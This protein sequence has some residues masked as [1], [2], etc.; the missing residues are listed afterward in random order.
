MRSLL[1][2]LG[3]LAATGGG[4][5]AQRPQAAVV[6]QTITVG[7]VFQ[8]A[9]RVELPAGGALL[10]PDTLVLPED[11]E[12]AA[13]RTLRP[14]SAGGVLRATLTYPLTAWRPG[15][16]TLPPV[17]LFLVVGP[18]TTR[19]QAELPPF[20][21]SSVL[22][23]D[24]AGVEPR[25]AKDVLGASRVW[26]PILVALLLLAL[27]AAAFWYWWRRR[28]AAAGAPIE[29]EV[30]PAVPPRAAALAR[31][32]A[33]AAS[34]LL[35]RGELKAWYDEVAETLRHYVS[36]VDP[37]LGVDLTTSELSARTRMTG[38]PESLELVRILGTADLVKFARARP[39]AEA[40]QHDLAA[41]RSWIER[42]PPDPADAAAEAEAR[43]VA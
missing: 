13:R 36:A 9:I 41:A 28:R 32:D 43:R 21:V 4:V 22:P 17:P 23:S 14:D 34:D 27:A 15:S 40:A 19:L 11:L 31:L 6:P 38:F 3:L 8:A 37:G 7:D 2:S 18:D 30:R 26:W 33:L 39:P 12:H 42:V 24:T 16:Y 25:P 35:T 10:A 1:V 5:V 20:E 29:V